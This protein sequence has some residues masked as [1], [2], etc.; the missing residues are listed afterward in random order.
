MR[1]CKVIALLLTYPEQEWVQ[2]IGELRSTAGVETGR[3]RR[4][5]RR[6]DGLFAHLE[7]EPLIELQETYVETFDRNPAHSLSIFEHRMGDSRE[8]GGAMASLVEEY[9]RSGFEVTSQELP[10]F[11]PVFL[12]FVSLIPPDEGRRRLA[13]IVDVGQILRQRLADAGSPYAGAFE[14]LLGLTSGAA[15]APV[16][17]SIRGRRDQNLGRMGFAERF[18]WS[19]RSE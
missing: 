3:S 9:R 4:A 13:D 2:S 15:P 8:R 10:D 11:I 7:R 16:L 19:R 12:E 5:G 6:L 1:L 17:P 18:G 14:A